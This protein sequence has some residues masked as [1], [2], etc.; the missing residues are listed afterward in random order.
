MTKFNID[1]MQYPHFREELEEVL[2]RNLDAG[3]SIISEGVSEGGGV[4][5]IID[6]ISNDEF[7]QIIN[8]LLA[9]KKEK[10]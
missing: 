10:D 3:I 5:I 1:I 4:S 2:R 9:V 7:Q 8:L 6:C